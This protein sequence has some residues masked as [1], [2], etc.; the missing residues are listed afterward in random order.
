M[1]ATAS[2]SIQQ[3]MVDVMNDVLEI[4]KN[5]RNAQQGFEFRGVEDVINVVGPLLRKHRVVITPFQIKDVQKERYE[6]KS[7]TAMVNATVTVIWH[8]TGPEGD[9]LSAETIGEAADSGDKALAKAQSVAYRIVL[10]RS[11]S[12]PTKGQPDPD[13]E[14]HERAPRGSQARTS[15]GRDWPAEVAVVTDAQA[16][17]DLYREINELGEMTNDIHA[18]LVDRG[19]HLRSQ[20]PAQ[21]PPAAAA[22]TRPPQVTRPATSPTTTSR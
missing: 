20:Q 10:E 11:F 4:G 19:T 16:M 18:L 15:S 22:R 9:F 1:T 17:A 14:S 12:I 3:L 13:A 8:F 21:T 5:S 6:T 7:G 2:T